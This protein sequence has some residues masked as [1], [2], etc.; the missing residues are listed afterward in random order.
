MARHNQSHIQAQLTS[1]ISA[2][3][4]RATARQ[5]Q[6]V[7]RRRKVDVVALVYTLVLGW[8]GGA[9]RNLAGLRR[10]YAR[11]TDTKLAPSTFYARFT[12]A[13]A[14]LMRRLAMGAFEQLSQHGLRPQRALR[15]FAK[16]FIADGSLIRLHD[17][18]AA[19]YPSVWT[20]HTKASAKLHLVIDGI[21]R[22]PSI[23]H[24]VP[25][26]RHDLPLLTTGSWCR[27]AL[28]IFDLAYYQGRLFQRIIDAHGYFLCRVKRDANFVIVSAAGR[29][30]IGKKTKDVLSAMHGHDF[31]CEV[32]YVH[33]NIP[34]RIWDKQHIRLRLLAVWRPDAARHYQ[35]ITNASADQLSAEVIPAV[36][37]LRWEIELI[38]REL[39]SQLSIDDMPS[40]NKAVVEALIY[41]ALLALAITRRL[42]NILNTGPASLPQR[43]PLERW[44]VIVRQLAAD[45]LHLLL[46]QRRRRHD[47]DG[48]LA[49]LLRHEG[50][51]PNR[52]R[53]LLTA[54]AQAGIMSA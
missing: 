51:D 22:T 30:S 17:A 46:P 14:E 1:L 3:R 47:L 29:D 13:L 38:F 41:A 36:Y 25:G 33:R 45:L 9:R 15:A 40:A 7:K 8:S 18:L 21:T 34:E 2:Q 20:N 49:A 37:A 39:K 54:R 52:H 24:V 53:L 32:D 48:T 12:P 31:E 23:T 11:A 19:H 28:L 50:A 5:L 27:G 42:H 35:Y 26:S 44:S 6:V 10:A 16:V 4:I 43:Y